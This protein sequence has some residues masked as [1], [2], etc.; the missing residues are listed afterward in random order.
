MSEEPLTFDLVAA[1]LRA[2]SHDVRSWI[3]VVSQKLADALPMRSRLLRGGILGNGS[4]EGVQID[5]DAFRYVLRQQHGTV[6]AER[7]HVV[8]GITLK[9]ERISVDE[10]IRDVSL[11]VAELATASEQDAA[12]IRSLLL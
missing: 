11:L 9:T 7:T 6:V 1:A 2:N 12:S 4:V 10:W 8:R 3:G 5:L